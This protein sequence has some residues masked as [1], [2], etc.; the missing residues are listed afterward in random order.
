MYECF[1][2]NDLIHTEVFYRVGE[3]IK[4]GEKKYSIFSISISAENIDSEKA[5]ELKILSENSNF[6]VQISS[7]LTINIPMITS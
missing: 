3:H 4:F 7:A 2:D 5:T 6:Y 1:K